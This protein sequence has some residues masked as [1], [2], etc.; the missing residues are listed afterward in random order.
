M[1]TILWAVLFTV[2]LIVEGLAI[3]DKRRGD[4]L[5][6]HVWLLRTKKYGR[7]ILM[8]AWAWLTWHFWLEPSAVSARSNIWWDDF[9]LIGLTV[10]LALGANLYEEE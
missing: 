6:E 2:G 8:P 4:T 3:Y 10:A 1:F 9:I 7:A 5:S